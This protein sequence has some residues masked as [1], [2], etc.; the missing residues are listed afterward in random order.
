MPKRA[1]KANETHNANLKARM[2]AR[3]QRDIPN[4]MP[5]LLLLI[6]WPAAQHLKHA[7]KAR[8]SSAMPQASAIRANTSYNASLC[9]AAR[10]PSR[11]LNT[12]SKRDTRKYIVQCKPARSSALPKPQI[13]ILCRHACK[14]C[15][16]KARA[17]QCLLLAR[18]GM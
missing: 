4:I 12:P 17:L 7:R 1:L 8:G 6:I 9:A 2:S 18:A 5:K 14:A 10:Y 11:F 13:R 16:C 3:P 15:A